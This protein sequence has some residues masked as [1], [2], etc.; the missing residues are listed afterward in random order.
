MITSVFVRAAYVIR[1]FILR[2]LWFIWIF[3][4]VVVVIVFVEFI[5]VKTFLVRIELV[6]RECKL[7]STLISS[8]TESD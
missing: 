4:V 8:Q 5:P 1:L 3:D 6:F 2:N 7:N